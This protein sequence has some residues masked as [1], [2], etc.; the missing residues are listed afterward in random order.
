MVV[1]VEL[2]H[3]K[4]LC[5]VSIGI[6]CQPA[7]VIRV[8]H[9]GP[10]N[11]SLVKPF[12]HSIHSLCRWCKQIMDLLGGPVLAILGRARV[13]PVNLL[14]RVNCTIIKPITYTS[15]NNS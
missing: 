14:A 11:A 13:G 3:E 2:G 10:V 8:D 5:F 7:L 15:I 12:A 6:E 9:T 1:L 4:A